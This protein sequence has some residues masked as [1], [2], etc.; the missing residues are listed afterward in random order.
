MTKK[1]TSTTILTPL[2]LA[3]TLASTQAIAD[4]E[5]ITDAF[6]NAKANLAFRLRYE[7]VNAD[8]PSGSVAKDKGHA[9]TLKTRMTFN[10][11]TYK[12]ASFGLEFDDVSAVDKNDYNIDDGNGEGPVIKDPE[13]TEVNQAFIAYTG[14]AETAFKYGRQRILLDNQRFVG[15]V[16]FRQNEQTYDGFTVTNSAIPD[17][18]VFASYIFAIQPITGETKD[19]RTTTFLLNAKYSGLPFGAF[20]GYYYKID[21]KNDSFAA[22]NKTVGIRFNGKTGD[23]NLKW[24]YGLEMAKQTEVGDFES[25]S[26]NSYDAN[27]LSIEGG[28]IISG[29]TAKLGYETLGSDDG[30]IAFQTPLGTKHAFQGWADQFLKTPNEGINDLQLTVAGK[31]AGIKLKAV[32][33]SYSSDE[34]N[35]SGD[36][37]LGSEIDL[38]AAKKFGAYGLS[39][40]YAAYSEGDETFGKKDTDKVWLTATAKF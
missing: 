23:D 13:Y 7:E 11:D 35:A 16:G 5:S 15:G 20:S 29:I 19:I 8:E 17:T 1:L 39:L 36:N 25:G 2:A 33:H 12:G 6:K 32:Y 14:P 18:K 37:D 31:A 4:S 9:A 22:S 28:A 30:I 3:C 26:I 27:Y 40:K 34:D 10:T 38:I 21:H 24:L